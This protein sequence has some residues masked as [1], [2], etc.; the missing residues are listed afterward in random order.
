MRVYTVVVNSPSFT[1][2]GGLPPIVPA[3]NAVGIAVINLPPAAVPIL[4]IF[5]VLFCCLAPY[6]DVFRSDAGEKFGTWPRRK[7]KQVN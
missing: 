5:T 2:T 4:F 1:F 7:W 3:P 6:P